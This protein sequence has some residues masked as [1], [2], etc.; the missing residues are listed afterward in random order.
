MI[1]SARSHTRRGNENGIEAVHGPPAQRGLLVPLYTP[2][3]GN[4]GPCGGTVGGRV[5]EGVRG[6]ALL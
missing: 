6:G 1:D 2:W 3:Y 5:G 4:E